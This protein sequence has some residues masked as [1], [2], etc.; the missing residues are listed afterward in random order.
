MK[1]EKIN[2]LKKQLASINSAL[3]KVNQSRCND[4]KL[5]FRYCEIDDVW[6]YGFF[7]GIFLPV[8]HCPNTGIKLTEEL[9]VYKELHE[10]LE[11]VDNSASL[12]YYLRRIFML[13]NKHHFPVDTDKAKRTF[14]LLKGYVNKL[15]QFRAKRNQTD[16]EV[17]G[18]VMKTTSYMFKLIDDFVKF[19]LTSEPISRIEIL[20][21]TAISQ[22]YNRL[23][24]AEVSFESR[25]LFL[26]RFIKKVDWSIERL[27]FL[28]DDEKVALSKAYAQK[29]L[30]DAFGKEAVN[31]T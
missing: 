8:E 27:P 19:G 3:V 11:K 9:G 24:V 23:S 13:L 17:L 10:A 2:Q 6:L 15:S 14:M 4:E 16:D 21:K 31:K 1:M 28:S 20:K 29:L 26:A 7:R 22:G 30:V 5:Y 18:D 12:V 25:G